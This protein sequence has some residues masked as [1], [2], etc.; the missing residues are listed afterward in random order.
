MGE[1]RDRQPPR[2]FASWFDPEAALHAVVGALVV[3]AGANALGRWA[4]DAWVSGARL[5]PALVAGVP[6]IAAISLL[7]LVRTRKRLLYI[8]YALV[9]VGLVCFLLASMGYTLPRSWL[10]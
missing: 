7:F 8:G 6:V 3:G 5:L 1:S 9:S 2:A 4:V 10:G